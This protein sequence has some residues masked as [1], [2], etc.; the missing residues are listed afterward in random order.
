[1]M[2]A[3]TMG[4]VEKFRHGFH[5]LLENTPEEVYQEKKEELTLVFKEIMSMGD[6]K[7]PAE[8]IAAALIRAQELG[9]ELPPTIANFS[10]CQMRLQN[11]VSDMNNTLLALRNNVKQL[12]GELACTDK[13][14]QKDPVAK[15]KADNRTKS[16]S[17]K[18]EAAGRWLS[19]RECP[20]KDYFLALAILL[21]FVYYVS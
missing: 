13:Y 6:E 5:Q 15:F 11:T 7:K 8:R 16:A 9:L 4:D 17:N 10:S 2:I 3:A 21:S 12:G 20:S 14:I 19:E 1:M 18:K